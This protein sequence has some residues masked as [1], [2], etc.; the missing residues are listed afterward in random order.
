MRLSLFC[1]GGFFF[2]KVVY[3]V[4]VVIDSIVTP[5]YKEA[6]KAVYKKGLNR[7]EKKKVNR[8]LLIIKSFR[9]F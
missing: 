4:I 7:F 1:R 9:K 2:G 5:V 6:T 3:I 8:N